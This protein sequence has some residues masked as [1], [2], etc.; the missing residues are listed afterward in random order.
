MKFAQLNWK[1]TVKYGL[2]AAL[3]AV[4]IKLAAR[5]LIDKTHDDAVKTIMKDPYDENLWE[6]ISAVSRIGP[7]TVVETNLRATEGKVIE[8]PLGS[9][10]KFPSLDDLMFTVAQF[11]IMPTPLETKIDTKVTIGKRAQKP[12]TIDFPIMVAPMAYGVALSL[13]AA[14]A[15]AKGATLAGTAFCAGQGPYNQK[16]RDAARTYIYQYNRGNWSKTPKILS[17]CAAIEIQFGQGAIAGVGNKLGA[18]QMSPEL[19]KAFGLSK[20][21][22][23]ISHSRQPLVQHPRD[24]AKLI[25]HLKQVSGGVPI[26]AKIGVSNYIEA[27]LDWLCNSGIDYIVLDGAEAATKGSPPILQDDFGVPT[28]FA[29]SRAVRWVEKNNFKDKVSLI[30]S[31]KIRTPGE[32]LKACALGA[33]A[34]YMG[35][36]SLFAMTHTQTLSALPFEP[37]TQAVW[38]QGKFAK[39]F[40]IEKGAQALAKFFKSCQAELE[41]GIKALGKTSLKQVNKEDLFALSELAAKGC[42]LPMA[43][44]PF[45]YDPQN[46]TVEAVLKTS[47]RILKLKR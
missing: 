13:Q 24:L 26:G 18:K 35:A 14:T 9:P 33:D 20:G 29:I 31:G 34:C 19:E 30:A 28:I 43:Y 25:E 37:P 21:K 22:D 36:I 3:G 4:G 38:Y 47:K 39:Q 23:A 8:R 6:L 46:K 11:Y 1:K 40:S 2:G 44:D 7:Q 15:L 5:K 45:Q 17:D 42:H 16:V 12:F 41:E 10:K 32:V 27:D